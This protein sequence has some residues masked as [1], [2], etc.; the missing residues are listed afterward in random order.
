[1]PL[2]LPAACGAGV[3][4]AAGAGDPAGPAAETAVTEKLQ[5]G[6]QSFPTDFWW[7]EGRHTLGVLATLPIGREL[8]R[9][10]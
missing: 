2:K 7:D 8:P 10:Y 5:A 4:A 3:G 1:M 6:V 9:D